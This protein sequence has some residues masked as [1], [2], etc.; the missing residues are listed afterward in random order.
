MHAIINQGNG[1]Y[2]VSQVFGYYRNISATDD[3][4][5]YVEGFRNPY[6]VVWDAEK[7]HLIKWLVMLPNTKYLIPQILIV[8]A[9]QDNWIT[10]ENGEGCV[11]FLTK[12]LIDLMVSTDNQLEKLLEK[13]R[14]TDED[15]VFDET[16]EIKIKSDIENLEWASGGFHDARIAEEKL[17]DDGSLYLRFDGTQGCEIE[18]W[19][20]GDLEY[21]SSSR[22]N[23]V[24]DPYWSGSTIIMQNGF[25]YLIDDCGVTVEEISQE[26]CYF[27]ARHMKYHIIPKL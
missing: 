18:V 22:H 6:Y 13:C 26:Y 8:E 9:N 14:Q 24:Y 12:E 15:Y 4:Q 5:R 23:E 20:W 3:Y 27:K 2:Y 21:D 17:Q 19:F 25:V 7:K 11:N 16:P 10:D 1:K